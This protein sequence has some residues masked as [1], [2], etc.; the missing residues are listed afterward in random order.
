MDFSA[1]AD[2]SSFGTAVRGCRDNFDF[3]LRFERIFFGL[4]PAAVFIALGLTRGLVLAG[5]PKV[6]TLGGSVLKIVKLAATILYGALCLTL[7][8][9]STK[10]NQSKAL[11]AS[12]T[13]LGFISSLCIIFVS[14]LEHPRSPRPSILLSGYLLLTIL[15]D[16]AQTRTLWLAS[17]TPEE[18]TFSRVVTA[19]VVVKAAVLVLECQ[20]KT[21]WINWD[22]KQHSPEETTGLFGLATLGWLQRLFRSGYSKVLILEDL[23]P[24]DGRII[25]ERLQFELLERLEATKSK[26]QRYG[27]GLTKA[28]ARTLSFALLLPMIPRLGLTAFRFC[29]PFLIRR[30]LK[31]LQ[32]PEDHDARN[33][34][35]GL[36]GATIIIY[37]GMASSTALY[38]YL[39][40]RALCMTR[41]SL[42]G[43]V[44]KKTTKTRLSV[45]GE[46]AAITLMSADVERIRLGFLNLHEFWANTVEV[47]IA[48]WLLERQLGLAFLAPLIVVI[49]C[50]SLAS[51]AN[52]WTGIRQRAW[53]DRIQSRVGLTANVISHMKHL[54]ISGLAAPVESLIQ[55][56]RVDELK[57]AAKFRTI[58]IIVVTLG[59][60]PMALSTVMTFAVTSEGL[61][62]S[63]IFTSVSYILLLA[64]PLS[65][66]FQNTP[67]L[68]AAFACLHRIQTFLEQPQRVDFRMAYSQDSE[69]GSETGSSAYADSEHDTKSA[70][71][72]TG[73]NFGWETN[74]IALKDINLTIPSSRLTMVVGPIASG[75]STLCTVLLGEIPVSRGHVSLSSNFMSRKVGYCGQ[76]PYLSNA[77]IKENIIGFSPFN[78]ARYDEAVKA[79]ML[80]QDLSI[81][82]KGDDTSVGSSGISLSGGQKQRVSIARALYLDTNFFIFDDILSGLDADTE[83]QVFERVFGPN[84]ILRH[85]NATVVLCTH[86]IRHLPAA[87]HVIALG[88]H[89][90]IVEQGSFSDLAANENYI[91]GLD[92]KP[93]EAEKRDS[94]QITDTKV[95]ISASTVVAT[96]KKV[97]AG[98]SHMDERSRLVGVSNIHRH[99]IASLGKT[100]VLAFTIFGVGWGFFYNFANIWL[101]FWAK[102]VASGTSSRSN[103][104]YIGI[105]ALFQVAYVASMFFCFLICFRLMIKVSG[106][107]LHKDALKTMINAPLRFFATTDTGLII[108][109]FSQDMTLIDNELPLA[110]TNLALDVC[111]AIGMAAVIA[112]SSPYL[113]IAYPFMLVI[114]YWVQK[115]YLRTS[116]QLRLLDL[117]AK[118]PLYSHFLDTI[119]GVA[120][121]R[122]FGWIQDGIDL[123]QSLLSISLKP[124]YLLAMVQRWLGFA[125]QMI[126]AVLAVTVVTLATQLRSSTAMTGASLI[127]LMTLGNILNY[128]VRWYTQIE[129]SI[130][131]VS[132]LKSFSDHVKSESLEVENVIPPAEWPMQGAI[133]LNGVSASYDEE[134]KDE[135]DGNENEISEKGPN[136]ALNNLNLTIQPGEKIAICGRS[137]SGKSSTILLLLRLLDPLSFT[138]QNITIDSLPLH[139]IDRST[140]RQRI[141]AVPQDPVFLPDGTSIMVNLD[142]YSVSSAAECEDVLSVVGLS[143][144]ITLRGGIG[145]ALTPASLSQGQKQLF[146]LARAILRRRIRSRDH[147]ATFGT[148]TTSEKQ[149]FSTSNTSGGILLLDEVSSSVDR[150]TD[151]AMQKIIMDEFKH[152]TI[153]MVSHRL[154]MVMGFDRVVVMERGSIVEVGKPLELK[155]VVG[156]KFAG[157]VG[158]GGGK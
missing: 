103:S 124:T 109:L 76:T 129:T 43:A 90:T 65:Y 73:G 93:L 108:N 98:F 97:A 53:M 145:E 54:R 115:F 28:L 86:S 139:K 148:M 34:G 48:T 89:G 49:V 4:V 13:S 143:G 7:L 136:L 18:S 69:T 152:Y 22:P 158:R 25:T 81:L 113:A 157:L 132:R 141:I 99:Y 153:V 9:F 30:L 127:T 2:D 64:D 118:S 96:P 72:I 27:L 51:F 78:Q 147:E 134:E 112:T 19:A 36:I 71:S 154:E 5:R 70:I 38:W 32:K 63:S 12:S 120:T 56:M 151:R 119:N 58:Y 101:T 137:G 60:L 92:I 142:P 111:N 59:Y 45:S 21:K 82:P 116:R 105:Y 123:N 31:L 150:D 80:E 87:D 52:R 131:A 79:S 74:K 14:F 77:S 85:R 26:G 47:A 104:F 83:A 138:S 42:V 46:S 102:D 39:H 68:L 15:F 107:K 94:T 20:H 35:Y 40:E 24:L 62:V 55:K 29:Q 16:I 66:L 156:G 117:E 128:I 17:V 61:D 1:C 146:S 95:A 110:I 6:V 41:G 50:I 57:S 100:S 91:Q 125:L 130:G 126:V 122:A 10:S 149:S 23:Y 144:L 135:N 11:F 75:K 106:S 140:L 44:Y 67:N 37:T 133:E 121:F 8:V 155:G 33:S 88:E 84:G 114:L 3:T